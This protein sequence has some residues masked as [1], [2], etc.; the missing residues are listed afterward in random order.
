MEDRTG[1]QME[2]IQ[3]KIRVSWSNPKFSVYW[4]VSILL[5]ATILCYWPF[6]FQIF[7]AKNDAIFSY[8]PYRYHVVE[9]L[10]QGEFPFWNPY[11]YL[12]TPIYGD[13]QSGVWNPV[14]WLLACVG[15]YTLY[16]YQWESLF[17]IFVGG[18]GMYYLTGIWFREQWV[19][20]SIALAYLCSGF[21]VHGQIIVWLASGACIPFIYFFIYQ[22]RSRGGIEPILGAAISLYF[23]FVAG[24]PSFFIL[25][26]YQLLFYLIYLLIQAIRKQDSILLKRIFRDG[27]LFC[28]FTLGLC[29]PALVSYIETL[30]LYIRGGG[31]TYSGSL[32]NALDYRCLVSW[33]FPTFTQVKDI[34]F[35]LDRSMRSLYIGIL[36]ILFLFI[37][38]PRINRRNLIWIGSFI[39]M[40]MYILGDCT[41]VHRICY[42]ILPGMDTFRHAAA[43]RVIV[44]I[45]L[46]LLSA[47]SMQRFFQDRKI[48]NT[49]PK[50]LY[51]LIG[52]F[53]IISIWALANSKLN[54]GGFPI[55][56]LN[57]YNY[58]CLQLPWS[59]ALGIDG[60]IQLFTCAVFILFLYQKRP[61]WMLVFLGF[62]NCWVFAQ[63]K[64]PITFYGMSSPKMM[65]ERVKS[66]PEHGPLDKINTAF[67][68][69]HSKDNR[70][71]KAAM[72]DMYYLKIPGLIQSHNPST[73][74]YNHQKFYDTPG[75]YAAIAQ[76][77][78]A[79]LASKSVTNFVGW[80]LT[81]SCKSTILDQKFIAPCIG[82][83]IAEIT[84]LTTNK[85][86]IKT[87][88][89][90]SSI[91]TIAQSY[92]PYWI[93]KIDQKPTPVLKANLAF[94]GIQLPKGTHTVEFQ[95]IP[96]HTIWAGII[97]LGTCMLI[98]WILF[99]GIKKKKSSIFLE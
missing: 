24:Y 45:P 20:L 62:M 34:A 54:L 26:T 71:E 91:L 72:L 29:L 1:K 52:C 76:L 85:I 66:S 11:I 19:Q 53:L 60:I 61:I 44:M 35:T 96:T 89:S 65:N 38:P 33:I 68:M 16:T 75:C 31:M 47:D 12:G 73:Y 58:W 57:L 50:R 98:L 77:P 7:T 67:V 3:K 95:F 46:L 87:Q 13:M 23:L 28:L 36:P 81:D 37:Y 93:A 70:N 9:S 55:T 97:F 4:G 32:E 2:N 18:V 90:D 25:I 99:K 22:I 49:I 10:R 14:L 86:L 82:G 42:Y 17:Y 30:P 79:Y 48:S 94:M 59:F 83:G 21:M 40:C 69:D 74:F 39:L 5:I 56:F 63:M 88:S 15:R 43:L 8:L 78:F 64:M 92:H 80:N 84:A 6:A 41:P 51:T 27:G